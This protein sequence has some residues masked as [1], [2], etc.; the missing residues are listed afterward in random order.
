MDS[1]EQPE[2]G[3]TVEIALKG[4]VVDIRGIGGHKKVI[5]ETDDVQGGEI[6]VYLHDTVD[7]EYAE[8]HS[9]HRAADIQTVEPGTERP[10]E[11]SGRSDTTDEEVLDDD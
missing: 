3:E 4:D 10:S 1:I 7:G 2:V 9:D 6:A 5:I 11:N 8:D